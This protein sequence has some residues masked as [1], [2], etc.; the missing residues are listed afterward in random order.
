MRLRPVQRLGDISYSVYLWHWP[1]IILAPF[2]LGG[3]LTTDTRIGILMLTVLVAW[4]SKRFVED[5]LRAAP[6]L[7][8]RRP[9]W[10]LAGSACATGAVF[11]VIAAALGAVEAQIS[12]AQRA[13]DRVLASRPACFGAASRDPARACRNPK[14]RLMVAPTPIEAAKRRNAPCELRVGLPSVCTFGVPARRAERTIALV[15]DSHASHWR[16]AVAVLAERNRWHGLSMTRSGCPLSK[17][18]KVLAEP[19]R[20]QCVAWNRAVLRFLRRHP[21]VKTVFVS[22]ISGGKGFY[23]SGG[24]SAWESGVAGY[25]AAWRALPRSVEQVVVIRDTPKAEAGTASCVQE[26]LRRR[27]PAGGACALSRSRVLDADPAAVAAARTG[28]ARVHGVDLTRFICDR[29]RCFPVVG[30]ALVYKDQHHLTTVFA[31]T[32]APFLQRALDR[33]AG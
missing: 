11:A 3:A 5:P 7:L 25:A 18:T 8:R 21:E 30:G 24:R 33:E 31:E 16:A 10:T 2:A 4:L 13:T 27:R 29:R 32:L 19:A 22:Q 26:A 9:A 6:P 12:A 1:L 23:P 17:A 15:G 14:L 28:A 20:S